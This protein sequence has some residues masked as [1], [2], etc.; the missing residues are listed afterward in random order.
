[1]IRRFR[2]SDTNA[3]RA[4][5]ELALRDA[6]ALLDGPDAL[7]LDSDLDDIATS[8]IDAGGDFLVDAVDGGIVAMGALRPIGTALV[9]K[10]SVCA[11]IRIGSVD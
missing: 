8:Y 7:A 3:I 10:L 9:A 11:S 1:M 4:L 6:G 5:H 2:A